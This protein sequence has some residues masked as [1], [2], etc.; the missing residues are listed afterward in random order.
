MA[1]QVRLATC[2]SS[3][4]E[5]KIGTPFSREPQFGIEKIHMHY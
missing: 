1:Q 2:K 3:R 5:N 4:I